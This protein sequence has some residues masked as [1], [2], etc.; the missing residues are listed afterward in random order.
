MKNIYQSECDIGNFATYHLSTS[1]SI[2]VYVIYIEMRYWHKRPHQCPKFS[3]YSGLFNLS[4]DYYRLRI[5]NL[6]SHEM[7]INN[8]EINV[9]FDSNF[10]L[11]KQ[12]ILEK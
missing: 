4:K 7:I 3:S 6:I 12:S 11:V 9:A 1:T 5:F 8:F 2:P 10:H